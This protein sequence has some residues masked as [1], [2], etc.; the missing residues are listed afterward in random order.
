MRITLEV[1]CAVNCVK[2]ING[3]RVS[4]GCDAGDLDKAMEVMATLRRDRILPSV[5]RAYLWMV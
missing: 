5:V 3:F 4:N 2:I 1:A